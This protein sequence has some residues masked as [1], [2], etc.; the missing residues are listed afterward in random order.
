MKLYTPQHG[1][2]CGVDPHAGSQSMKKPPAAEAAG[3]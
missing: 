2:F 1:V 3:G